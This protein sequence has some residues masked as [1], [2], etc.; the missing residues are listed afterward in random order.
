MLA[1]ERGKGGGG[2]GRG[3]RRVMKQ[4]QEVGDKGESGGG[5]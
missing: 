1:T 4:L 3:L 5:W 2:R